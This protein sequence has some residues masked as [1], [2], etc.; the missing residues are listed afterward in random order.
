MTQGD[1][2]FLTNPDLEFMRSED[3]A[4]ANTLSTAVNGK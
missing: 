4:H 3:R 1:F 2:F